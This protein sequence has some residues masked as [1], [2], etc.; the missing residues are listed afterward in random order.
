[1]AGRRSRAFR[2]RLHHGRS[3]CPCARARS[4][5]SPTLGLRKRHLQ[6]RST[7]PLR[8]SVASPLGRGTATSRVRGRAYATSR[9]RPLERVANN[10]LDRGD[11]DPHAGGSLPAAAP[12][13]PTGS[14]APSP[15]NADPFSTT[16]TSSQTTVLSA[17]AF[18]GAELEP[19]Q[20]AP[21]GF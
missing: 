20:S 4:P 13:P 17:G 5:T 8:R 2:C 11:R 21:P 18:L 7:K 1:R 15:A 3:A 12:R 16:R 6:A 10:V 19:R 9:P 14:P